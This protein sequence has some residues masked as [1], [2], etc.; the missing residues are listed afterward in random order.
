M[1][2]TPPSQ[3]LVNLLEIKRVHK[4]LLWRV[5]CLLPVIQEDVL[6]IGLK[7]ILDLTLLYLKVRGFSLHSSFLNFYTNQN[8]IILPKRLNLNF[9]IYFPNALGSFFLKYSMMRWCPIFSYI[10][11]TTQVS[12]SR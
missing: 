6:Q 5:M 8:N 3:D 9:Q 1:S 7:S 11:T 12:S 2:F 10:T 4:K